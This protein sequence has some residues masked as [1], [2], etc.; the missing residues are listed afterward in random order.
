[1]CDQLQRNAHFFQVIQ[2]HQMQL[3]PPSSIAL[4]YKLGR[5]SISLATLFPTLLPCH[6]QYITVTTFLIM[7]MLS[8]AIEYCKMTLAMVLAK[9]QHFYQK[10]LTSNA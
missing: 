6:V 10:F 1:M 8:S 5:I 3:T 7:C 2:L 9:R 4:W